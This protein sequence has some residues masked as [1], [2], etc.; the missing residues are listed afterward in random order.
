ML[1]VA[2]VVAGIVPT[3]SSQVARVTVV[4]QAAASV[5]Y[6]AQVAY[7]LLLGA[8]LGRVLG[9]LLALAMVSL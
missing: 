7:L 1:G 3:P 5:G 4:V 2:G 6:S 8:H 9:K